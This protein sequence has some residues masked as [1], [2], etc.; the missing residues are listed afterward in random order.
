MSAAEALA[1]WRSEGLPYCC[2]F[3]ASIF[4]LYIKQVANAVMIQ[5]AGAG[6]H[7]ER[8]GYYGSECWWPDARRRLGAEI[9]EKLFVF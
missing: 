5:V 3:N 2:A 6:F 8:L 1:R 7:S 9:S 4:H